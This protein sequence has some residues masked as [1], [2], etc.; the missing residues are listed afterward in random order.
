MVRSVLVVVLAL[1]AAASMAAETVPVLP[2]RPTLS[3]TQIVFVF[4]GDLWSVPREGGTAV[5]LTTGPGV[6]TNPVFSPDGTQIAFTGE[7]DGNVDVFIM[8][9]AGGVPRRLTWHP[10]ADTVLGW[11][12]DGKRI[13]FTSARNAYSRFSELFTVPAEGGPEEKV[14]LPM[15]YEG[16]YAPDGTHLAYVPLGR[17][18][19]F[20]KRYRGGR[21]TPIWIADLATSHIEKVPRDNSNDFNPM[22]IGD[23]VCFLSDRNGPVT[24]FSYDVKTKKVTELVQNQGLD[25]KSAG[26]GPG[27]IVYEQFGSLNLYDLTTGK[28]SRVPLT[29]AGD[30]LQVRERLVKVGSALSNAHISPTGVR[31]VFEGRGEIVTV[32]AEKVTVPAT[33]DYNSRCK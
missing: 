9:A 31:A 33:S 7:Y 16:A 1:W 2:Q 30:M 28:T 3:R 27:A 32:P 15:G 29:V 17:A 25:L 14:P 13:L 19:M 22:W 21:T 12:P 26:A 5:R 18:F 24:L 4:A 23:R 11:T 6:E 8:P 10:A 20:W